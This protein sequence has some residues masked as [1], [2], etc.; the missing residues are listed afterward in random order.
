MMV[1]A[2]GR[3]PLRRIAPVELAG[4]GLVIVALL[5]LARANEVSS[6]R[7]VFRME[8]GP[9]ELVPAW[10]ASPVPESSGPGQ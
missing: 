5:V 6:S 1:V 10:F 9:W 4:M 2:F 3:Q 7:R 8:P